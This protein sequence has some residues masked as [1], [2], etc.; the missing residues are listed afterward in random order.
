MV[1]VFTDSL[2]FH[3]GTVDTTM[4]VDNMRDGNETILIFAFFTLLLEQL[5]QCRVVSALFHFLASWP[6]FSPF[7]F[8]CLLF[9]HFTFRHG[10]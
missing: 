2:N 6:C 4:V 7:R 5:L 3:V 1:S 9:K 10:F 8:L